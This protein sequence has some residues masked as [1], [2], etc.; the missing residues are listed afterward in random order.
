VNP[1]D[2]PYGLLASNGMEIWAIVELP[3]Y[4]A[5]LSPQKQFARIFN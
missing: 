5:F 4:R 3:A 2:K 1:F